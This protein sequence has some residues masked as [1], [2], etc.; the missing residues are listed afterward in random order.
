MTVEY[1]DARFDE[2]VVLK[3][4]E[5]LPKEK[6]K[7]KVVAQALSWWGWYPDASWNSKGYAT[8]PYH[9]LLVKEGSH[10]HHSAALDKFKAA[11][12]W[13]GFNPD[14][15]YKVFAISNSTLLINFENYRNTLQGKHRASAG[16]F[17]KTDWTTLPE[18]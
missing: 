14:Q 12:G 10:I 13:L 6:I 15:A 3:K 16:L 9:S 7:L 4:V 1:L 8:T 17:K 5:D 11:A 2:Y 18:S